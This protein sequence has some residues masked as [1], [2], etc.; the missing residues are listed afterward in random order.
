MPGAAAISEAERSRPAT[1]FMEFLGEIR[2]AKSK[3]RCG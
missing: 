1:S 2:R 3:R